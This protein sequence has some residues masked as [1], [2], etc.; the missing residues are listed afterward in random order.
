M[1]WM[2]APAPPTSCVISP[3]A[4]ATLPWFSWIRMSWLGSGSSERQYC[5]C[6][7]HQVWPVEDQLDRGLLQV[8]DH[9]PERRALVVPSPRK[10]GD[11][12]PPAVGGDRRERIDLA[13]AEPR[14][15]QRRVDDQDRLAARC[16]PG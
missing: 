13:G 3:R 8:E 7:L 11:R 12:Q 1:T 4:S 15:R 6:M 9:Q 16:R 2:S 14:A 10:R 5:G